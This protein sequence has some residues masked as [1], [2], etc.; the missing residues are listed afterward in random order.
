MRWG[1]LERKGVPIANWHSQVLRAFR[2]SKRETQ[3]LSGERETDIHEPS[4]LFLRS[5][6]AEDSFGDGL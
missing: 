2:G 4:R 6:S 3:K 1:H 5:N